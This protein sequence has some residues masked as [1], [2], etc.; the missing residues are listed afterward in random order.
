MPKHLYLK[1]LRHKEPF[2]NADFGGFCCTMAS[3]CL[4]INKHE[5]E[6]TLQTDGDFEKEFWLIREEVENAVRFFQD[7]QQATEFGAYGVSALVVPELT[8]L[9]VIEVSW[10]GTGFDFWLGS[11]DDIDFLFQKKA[12]LEVSGILDATEA[13]I[14][15]RVKIKLRQITPTDNTLP[16]YV[17][18]V[19]FNPLRIRV[20][21]K[22]REKSNGRSEEK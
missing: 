5:L 1:G 18:V 7:R 4:H 11:A 15:E 12:R 2:I 22:D 17:S 20:V 10:K 3:V 6:T 21:L 14:K 9:T 8:E 13:K 16:G 19:S